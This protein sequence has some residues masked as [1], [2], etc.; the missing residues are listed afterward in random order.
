MY[1]FLQI[2]HH[3]RVCNLH[4]IHSPFTYHITPNATISAIKTSEFILY[5]SHAV[6]TKQDPP[7]IDKKLSHSSKKIAMPMMTDIAIFFIE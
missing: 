4:K 5:H 6:S 2:S 7:L 3:I 1:I